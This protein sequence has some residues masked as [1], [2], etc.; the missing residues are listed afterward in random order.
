MKVLT[1]CASLLVLTAAISSVAPAADKPEIKAQVAMKEVSS[2]DGTPYKSYPQGQPQLTVLEITIPPHTALPW[3]QHPIPN[4]A[5]V[6]SGELT[7]EDRLSGKSLKVHAGQ[8]FAESVNSSHRGVTGDQQAVVIVT[9]SGV[10][11]TP[12]SI[13]DKGEKVEFEHVE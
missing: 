2:W 10:E 11:G 12:L 8:A 13:P 4:A 9:Y 7:V 5:Y 1:V 6:V 3:H